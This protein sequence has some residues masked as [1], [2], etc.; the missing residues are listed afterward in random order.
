MNGVDLFIDDLE[1]E[2]TRELVYAI[3]EI[4]LNSHPAIHSKIRFKIP[5]YFLHSWICYI[6]PLKTGGIEWCFIHGQRLEDPHD[7]LQSKDRIMIAG[8]EVKEP[9]DLNNEAVLDILYTAIEYDKQLAEKK[10]KK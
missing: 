10:K 3:N 7:I 1:D 5:F 8:I 4:I 6:N 9:E 2:S